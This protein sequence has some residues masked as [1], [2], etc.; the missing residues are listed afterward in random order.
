LQASQPQVGVRSCLTSSL[1]IDESHIKIPVQIL[2]WCMECSGVGG[3]KKVSPAGLAQL[4][5][6]TLRGNLPCDDDPLP[7]PTRVAQMVF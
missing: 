2:L 4:S 3:T 5:G 6:A 1:S 7:K